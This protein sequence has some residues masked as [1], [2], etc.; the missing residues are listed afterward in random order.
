MVSVEEGR[1]FEEE[2][3]VASREA[4]SEWKEVMMKGNGFFERI[5]AGRSSRQHIRL[6]R[7]V[8]E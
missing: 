8:S 4:A 2:K 3:L 6:H 1:R 7:D 5:T